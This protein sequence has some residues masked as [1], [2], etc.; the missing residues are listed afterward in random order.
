VSGPRWWRRLRWG[1]EQPTIT[2]N[3]HTGE[4]TCRGLRRRHVRRAERRVYVVVGHLQ[5][6]H[7]RTPGGDPA[8]LVVNCPSHL[9][10][11]LRLVRTEHTDRRGVL[12]LSGPDREDHAHG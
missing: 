4:V 5:A 3:V 8:P 9:H 2:L 12:V 7:L 11:W 1:S 10:R 6:Q